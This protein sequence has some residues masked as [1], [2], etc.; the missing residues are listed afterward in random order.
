M[1]KLPNL[2]FP[3]L[4]EMLK[5]PNLNVP[6][7][8]ERLKLPSLNVPNLREMPKLPNL[9]VEK[10]TRRTKNCVFYSYETGDCIELRQKPSTGRVPCNCS[11]SVCSVIT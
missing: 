4:H 2:N 9:I 8:C 5:L 3:N 11:R 6:N 7:L 10:Q 1:L